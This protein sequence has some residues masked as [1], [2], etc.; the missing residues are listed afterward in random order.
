M[1]TSD[2][3]LT[4]SNDLKQIDSQKVVMTVGSTGI[5]KS[6]IMNAIIQG[7]NKMRLDANFNIEA[8][9]PLK[10]LSGKVVF[11]IGHTN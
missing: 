6:T 4:L 8:V 5:G 7:S 10:T 1:K 9:Q 11:Q 3:I 2:Q